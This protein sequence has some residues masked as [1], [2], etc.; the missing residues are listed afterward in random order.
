MIT[1]RHTIS[2]LALAIFI[3]SQALSTDYYFS[4]LSGSSDSNDGLS[5]AS[6]KTSISAMQTVINSM[7]AGDNLYL[8]RGSIW[9]EAE[10]DLSEISGTSGSHITISAYGTGELPILSGE[11]I[12]TATPTQLGNVYTYTDSDIGNVNISSENSRG[13]RFPGLVTIDGDR[14]S[15]SR[16]PDGNSYLYSTGYTATSI[17]DA[18]GWT[19]NQWQGA[20]VGVRPHNWQWDVVQ[21]VSNTSTTLTTTHRDLLAEPPGGAKWYYF[22]NHANALSVNGE[23][24]TTDNSIKIYSSTGAPS[25]VKVSIIDTI[26][27]IEDANYW[28]ISYV[29]LRGGN[30]FGAHVK[31]SDYITFDYCRISGIGYC[32]LF[33]WGVVTEPGG[34]GDTYGGSVT[35]SEIVDC[36]NNS[37]L[38]KYCYVGTIK[39][40]Y[41]HRSGLNNAYHNLPE[42]DYLVGAHLYATSVQNTM[43]SGDFEMQYNYFDSIGA[44]IVLNHL[45]GDYSTQGT[46]FRMEYN[47]IQN[48]GMSELADL[49]AYY[50]V[51]DPTASTAYVRHNFILDVHNPYQC[52]TQNGWGIFVD[53]LTHA[54]YWDQDTY[55]QS[56]EY[57]SIENCNIALMTN[58]GIKRTFRNNKVHNPNAT[59][60]LYPSHAQIIHHGYGLPLN[61]HPTLS[62]RDSIYSN[63]I[64]LSDNAAMGYAFNIT[65]SSYYDWIYPCDFPLYSFVDSNTWMD[66][67]NVMMDVARGY[68][69]SGGSTYTTYED[70]VSEWAARTFSC[71]GGTYDPGNQDTYSATYPYAYMFKNWSATP[72]TFNLTGTYYD[73]AGTPVTTSVSVPT[74]YSTILYSSVAKTDETMYIDTSLVPMFPGY[75][76]SPVTDTCDVHITLYDTITSVDSAGW[77]FNNTLTAAYGDY[78]L[79]Y[80]GTVQYESDWNCEG[81]HGLH[82]YTERLYSDAPINLADSFS[83]QF[84]YATF[85]TT[86][87]KTLAAN[88]ALT[89]SGWMLQRGASGRLVFITENAAGVQDSSFSVTSAIAGGGTSYLIQVIVSKTYGFASILVN[90]VYKTD[91]DSTIRTD[92][93]TNAV[94]S[95]M[96]DAGRASK[97]W[98]YFDDLSINWYGQ[99]I[100]SSDSC[101]VLSS[102]SPS[103]T[104]YCYDYDAAE[105]VTDVYYNPGNSCGIDSVIV[106][107]Q[108]GAYL[109]YNNIDFT[110]YNFNTIRIGVTISSINLSTI[111]IRLDSPDGTILAIIGKND[112]Y[113]CNI[114]SIPSSTLTGI[115]D[116]FLVC[117]KVV[118]N[119]MF[120][121]LLFAIDTDTNYIKYKPIQVGSTVGLVKIDGRYYGRAVE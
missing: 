25:E 85:T 88:K 41:I 31:R 39:N 55:N 17:T 26:L 51:S 81:T 61:L 78:S 49:G 90:G 23:W 53:M 97:P 118:Y 117:D 19:T 34:I 13:Y 87:W 24:A 79:N 47:Y 50:C 3:S 101:V 72:T 28:D 86:A 38:F 111:E 37:I 115:H 12:I 91:T 84:C 77:Y 40:N 62:G 70:N 22:M 36:L 113:G 46:D 98:S 35:N 7:V 27:N 75:Y 106:L 110:G 11:K 14:K 15:I 93:A 92:F 67:D 45:N 5:S 6:P 99:T 108:D 121:W 44:G 60:L 109:R 82:E 100:T 63:E 71:T 2:S 21:V 66:P 8:R 58:G 9:Y 68:T 74:F 104:L 16:Y 114:Q 80:A 103:D 69:T 32:G 83:I 120:A 116:I 102:R 10:L 73:A 96:D 33:F 107:P 64:V 65:Y 57:N 105:N 119:T 52:Y 94:L 1:F 42:T 56:T 112:S 59:N 76:T 30:M 20:M 89:G 54:V 18:E 4:T 48:Y 43:G 95:F 29:E